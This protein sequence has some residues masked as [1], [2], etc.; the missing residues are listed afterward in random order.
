MFNEISFLKVV[1]ILNSYRNII[2]LWCIYSICLPYFRH[3]GRLKKK[4]GEPY[5][6]IPPKRK[7]G[8]WFTLR[9]ITFLLF[10]SLQFNSLCCK[11]TN[12]EHMRNNKP[13]CRSVL[14][15]AR[16]ARVGLSVPPH[17]ARAVQFIFHVFRI[18]QPTTQKPIYSKLDDDITTATVC[19]LERGRVCVED[20][21]TLIYMYG[22]VTMLIKQAN[23]RLK[24]PKKQI[25][26]YIDCTCM[27]RFIVVHSDC[28]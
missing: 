6:I 14:I 19:G 9:Q 8:L 11:W 16:C 13:H 27:Q 18:Y 23:V 24:M 1:R 15:P 10:C 20:S 3:I 7:G 4:S 22:E 21:E 26:I 17:L 28:L 2:W 25:Y 12:N 5:I